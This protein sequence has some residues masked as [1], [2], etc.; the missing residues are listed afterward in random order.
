MRPC[1]DRLPNPVEESGLA[2][3]ASSGVVFSRFCLPCRR[4]WVRVPLSA[5][6]NPL[7]AAGFCFESRGRAKDGTPADPAICELV[8]QAVASQEAIDL[9][10][11]SE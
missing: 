9:A 1:L 3:L 8:G 11:G 6:G 5:L 2:G 10:H 7:E 4:S